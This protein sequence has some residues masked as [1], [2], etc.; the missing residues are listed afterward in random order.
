MEYVTA[1]TKTFLDLCLQVSNPANRLS[2]YLKQ[3]YWINVRKTEIAALRKIFDNNL[4]STIVICLSAFCKESAATDE[5]NGETEA[6]LNNR[7]SEDI[8]DGAFERLNAIG[9]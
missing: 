7:M 5:S 2:F 6:A 3:T 9:Q 4:T 8:L 1:Q